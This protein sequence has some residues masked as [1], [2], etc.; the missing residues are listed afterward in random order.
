MRIAIYWLFG[1]TIGPSVLCANMSETP[2]PPV[3]T[4]LQ[5]MEQMSHLWQ[6]L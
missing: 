1:M 6:A 4:D 3:I 5:G 2:P